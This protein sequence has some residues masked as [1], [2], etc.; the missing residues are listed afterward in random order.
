MSRSFLSN[1]PDSM[2]LELERIKDSI[3][4]VVTGLNHHHYDP[5]LYGGKVHPPEPLRQGSGIPEEEEVPSINYTKDDVDS[6][7]P[8]LTPEPAFSDIRNRRK[9]AENDRLYRSEN[10]INKLFE[11]L[12]L[13]ERSGSSM[14]FTRYSLGSALEEYN[15]LNSSSETLHVSDQGSVNSFTGH[16]NITDEDREEVTP[17]PGQMFM[18]PTER[19]T[20][21]VVIN[22]NSHDSSEGATITPH[23]HDNEIIIPYTLGRISQQLPHDCNNVLSVDDTILSQNI[24]AASQCDLSDESEVEESFDESTRLLDDN[25]Q[26]NSGVIFDSNLADVALKPE[27]MSF[28]SKAE[29]FEFFHGDGIA[30]KPLNN[31]DVGSSEDVYR[32]LSPGE[33]QTILTS[34]EPDIQLCE[35]SFEGTPVEPSSSSSSQGVPTVGCYDSSSDDDTE[36]MI[37]PESLNSDLLTTLKRK[38]RRLRPSRGFHLLRHPSTVL[39][40]GTSIVCPGHLE[41]GGMT[42]TAH[43]QCKQCERVANTER[44]ND[45]ERGAVFGTGPRVNVMESARGSTGFLCGLTGSSLSL[46][47][48]YYQ[49]RLITAHE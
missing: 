31:D 15:D 48:S 46:A 35:T 49:G 10:D 41:S 20:D 12:N 26:C 11:I 43:N 8:L 6:S 19:E 47:D 24:S 5:T 33:I 22:D 36:P 37:L 42:P 9:S 29:M 27:D 45:T 17:T 28:R 39:E 18:E 4:S 38:R 3:D 14:K 23:N 21:G 7:A 13:K 16:L 44:G 25:Y 30:Y 1:D 34:E 40:E 32:S 2:I